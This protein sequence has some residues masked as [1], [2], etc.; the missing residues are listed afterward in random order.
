[1]RLS[2]IRIVKLDYLHNKIMFM[3]TNFFLS[4]K[5]HELKLKKENTSERKS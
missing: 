1:M 5:E 3:G 4:L 2:Y